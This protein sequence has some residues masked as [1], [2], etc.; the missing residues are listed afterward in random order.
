MSQIARPRLI[1]IVSVALA[2]AVII[3]LIE[4]KIGTAVVGVLSTYGPGLLGILLL[5]GLAE[6]SRLGWQLPSQAGDRIAPPVVDATT[7]TSTP[8]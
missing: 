7:Q 6:G 1:W 3:A 4:P 5:L 8:L 2:A